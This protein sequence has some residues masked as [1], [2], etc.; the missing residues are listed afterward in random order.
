MKIK[1]FCLIL[2]GFFLFP[3]VAFSSSCF[4]QMTQRTHHTLS[5][6][7]T[8]LHAQYSA[9]YTTVCN[10]SGNVSSQMYVSVHNGN[11]SNKAVNFN[12]TAS[13]FIDGALDGFDTTSFSLDTDNFSLV[14][15]DGNRV[16]TTGTVILA[17]STFEQTVQ[18]SLD[19]LKTDMNYLV[20]IV[21]LFGISSWIIPFVIKTFHGSNK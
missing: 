1:I 21:L 9:G 16:D 6:F 11:S 13:C 4:S 15:S 20:Q 14:D 8:S 10:S 19:S 3:C 18:A 12:C 17:P 2:F 7:M 5:S